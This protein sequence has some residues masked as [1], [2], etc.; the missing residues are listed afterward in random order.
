MVLGPD[1]RRLNK[2]RDEEFW[3]EEEIMRLVKSNE[4]VRG[5]KTTTT[6]TAAGAAAKTTAFQQSRRTN[7]DRFSVREIYTFIGI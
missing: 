5:C 4:S 1:K 6:S 7:L 3:L 2:N